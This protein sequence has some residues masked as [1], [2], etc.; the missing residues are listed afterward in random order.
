MFRR[1]K[2]FLVSRVFYFYLFH[3]ECIVQRTV[4]LRFIILKPT[5]HD[6]SPGVSSDLA[7]DMTVNNLFILEFRRNLGGSSN[8]ETFLFGY[9]RRL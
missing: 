9:P 8:E 7:G 6:Y 5:R 4:T 1:E 2:L 3:E